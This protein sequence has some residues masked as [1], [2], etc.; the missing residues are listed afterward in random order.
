MVPTNYPELIHID[1][2]DRFSSSTDYYTEVGLVSDTTTFSQDGESLKDPEGDI[3]F[4]FIDI[5]EAGFIIE[6]KP[7]TPKISGPDKTVP[8]ELYDFEVKSVDPEG[9][10]LL[11]YVDW[12]DNTSGEWI[13]PYPSG[14]PVIV[15]HTWESRGEYQ[16]RVRAKDTYGLVSDWGISEIVIPK[17]KNV[18]IPLIFEWMIGV[19][20]NVLYPFSYLFF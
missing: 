6:E 18:H 4:P 1:K 14:E 11:Y 7:M 10:P 3:Q 13:G 12:G 19:L 5:I 17:G 20:Q 16:M 2:N 8:G 15:S 9:T